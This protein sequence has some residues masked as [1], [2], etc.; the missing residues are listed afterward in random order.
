LLKA[1]PHL[2][3]QKTP[4]IYGKR[5]T[6]NFALSWMGKI[7]CPKALCAGIQLHQSDLC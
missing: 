5:C 3:R 4:P 6:L 2:G 1:S 7:V